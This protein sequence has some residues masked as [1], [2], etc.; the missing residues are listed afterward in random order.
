MFA[1]D[2]T[3]QQVQALPTLALVQKYNVAGPRYTSYPT[4]V[5]FSE[6]LPS[7]QFQQDL[8]ANS[9]SDRPLSLY[10]HIPFCKDICY[11]C[12]CNKVVTR[13]TQAC[14]SYLVHLYQEIDRMAALVGHRRPVTQL[15][16]GGGTPTYLSDL[17]ISELMHKLKQCFNLRL[18]DSREYSIEIDPRTVSVDKLALLWGLGFNRLSLGI[19]DFDQQVQ[20]AVNRIQSVGM[21]EELMLGARA[22]GYESISFDLIYGLPKQS[23]ASYSKTLDR[24]IAMAPDRISC[25]GY[26][27]LPERFVSQ[28]AIDRLAVPSAETR[29]DIIRHISRRLVDVGYKYIGMDHFVLPHDDLAAAERDGYLQRNFQGYSTQKADDLIGLGVS[30]ISSIDN[31]YMQNHANLDGYYQSIAG[32]NDAWNRGF[33]LSV[34]DKLR[35]RVIQDLSCQLRFSFTEIDCEFDVD[36]RVYFS[37]ELAQLQSLEEDGLV[38]V[39]ADGVSVSD[40]GR[41]LLRNVCMVFDAYLQGSTAFSKTI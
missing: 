4:A 10:V 13:Q 15:H 1:T 2:K 19:Q 30:A 23:V 11:Y 6:Q 39:T 35:R 18:D 9:D 21:V 20:K 33:E 27:H 26:A 17:Q 28:R 3:A 5:Q 32:H 41:Y 24:V 36:S 40:V 7:Q 8:S 29:L 22:I 16:W 34:D 31:C 25:Y 37:K 38:E 14:E 12:G